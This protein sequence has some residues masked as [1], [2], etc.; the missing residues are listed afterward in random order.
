M[1]ECLSTIPGLLVQWVD[2]GQ[3]HFSKF[4]SGHNSTIDQKPLMV[5]WFILPGCILELLGVQASIRVGT[6]IHLVKLRVA[7][8]D[9][10]DH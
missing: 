9:D 5:V 2:T 10:P 7:R 4:I 3:L 8:H 1:E 6:D